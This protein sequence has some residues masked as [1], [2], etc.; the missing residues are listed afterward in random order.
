ML[1]LFLSKQHVL[2]PNWKALSHTLE[3]AICLLK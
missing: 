1:I 2:T 3:V